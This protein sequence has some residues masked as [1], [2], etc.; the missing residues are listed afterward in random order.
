[1]YGTPHSL[2][3]ASHPDAT[4]PT[5]S[6]NCLSHVTHV[7]IAPHTFSPPLSHLFA[8]PCAC[9][10][11]HPLTIRLQLLHLILK[12]QQQCE[13]RKTRHIKL[14]E[15]CEVTQL[16]QRPPSHKRKHSA[17]PLCTRS[18]PEKQPTHLT[19]QPTTDQLR[20]TTHQW[21]ALAA[22]AKQPVLCLVAPVLPLS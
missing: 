7:P 10:P 1:M 21:R 16:A 19:Q 5:H 15:R 13:A 12:Q 17:L 22:E 3:N 9:Q 8:K 11:I 14:G 2:L 20:P 6:T 4:R 18:R